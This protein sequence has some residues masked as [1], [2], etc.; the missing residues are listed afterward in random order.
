LDL[1]Q[2]V[3]GKLAGALVTIRRLDLGLTDN[4]AFRERLA[5]SRSKH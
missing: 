3:R 4:D 5:T 2:P 1:S